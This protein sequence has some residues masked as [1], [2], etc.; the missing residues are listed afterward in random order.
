MVVVCFRGFAFV[1]W[2]ESERRCCLSRSVGLEGGGRG[3]GELGCSVVGVVVE[4]LFVG[5]SVWFVVCC[6]VSLLVFGCTCN[7]KMDMEMFGRS[8]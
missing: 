8:K 4:A 3:G 2:G 5:C 6:Y 7:I 1:A